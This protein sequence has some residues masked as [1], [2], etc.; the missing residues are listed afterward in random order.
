MS[1]KYTSET[2]AAVLSALYE[3]QSINKVAKEYKIPKGTVSSWWSRKGTAKSATQKKSE[4]IGEYLLEYLQTNLKT[5]KVQ[6]EHFQDKKWLSNQDAGELAV[7]HGVLTDKAVR[8]L[9]AMANVPN[10]NDSQ[11]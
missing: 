10:N 6:A 1:K 4:E 11:S 2:K 7:L 8:L 3:G 5:L 9:E